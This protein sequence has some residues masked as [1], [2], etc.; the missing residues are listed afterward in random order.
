M[1]ILEFETSVTKLVGKFRILFSDPKKWESLAQVVQT[2]VCSSI[3]M[4]FLSHGIVAMHAAHLLQIC[5]IGA[6]AF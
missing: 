4:Q 1:V 3:R 6:F 5:I 2:S